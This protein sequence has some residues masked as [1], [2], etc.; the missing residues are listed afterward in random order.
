MMVGRWCSGALTDTS[1]ATCMMGAIRAEAGGS[2]PAVRESGGRQWEASAVAWLAGGLWLHHTLRIT[3]AD[4]ASDVRMLIVPGT[5]GRGRGYIDMTSSWRPSRSCG[6]QTAAPRTSTARSA[7]VISCN[8]L[9]WTHRIPP[10]VTADLDGAFGCPQVIHLE[11]GAPGELFAEMPAHDAQACVDARADPPGARPNL[12]LPTSLIMIAARYRPGT[13]HCPQSAAPA[14][15]LELPR[16]RLPQPVAGRR[17]SLAE[18][19]RAKRL[20]PAR[21]PGRTAR[22]GSGRA[23]PA[24]SA[25]GRCGS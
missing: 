19:A 12:L 2:Y 13:C 8:V 4:G 3:K 22:P 20:R 1:G 11:S 17:L 6:P 10:V 23:G 21:C 5:C 14:H 16:N 24:G 9:P 15:R 7:A 25:R 18:E